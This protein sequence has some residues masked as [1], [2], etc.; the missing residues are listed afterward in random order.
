MRR[1]RAK[2]R[3]CPSPGA[4]LLNHHVFSKNI[5]NLYNSE[6]MKVMAILRLLCFSAPSGFLVSVQNHL[7]ACFAFLSKSA[8]SGMFFFSLE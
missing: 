8:T 1:G 6:V 5:T 4:S 3:N 7:F 2:N